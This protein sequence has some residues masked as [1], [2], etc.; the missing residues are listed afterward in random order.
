MTKTQYAR[1]PY[2]TLKA[3]AQGDPDAIAAVL[4]HYEGYIAKLSLRRFY[5]EYGGIY[6]GVDETIRR[7]LEIKLITGLLTFDAA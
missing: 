7:R 2:G 3:A 4:R 6:Y 1:L 5:D